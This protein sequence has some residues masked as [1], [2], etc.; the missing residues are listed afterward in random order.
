MVAYRFDLSTGPCCTPASSGG[1]FERSCGEGMEVVRLSA[2]SNRGA[3]SNPSLAS[4]RNM[5]FNVKSAECAS[6]Y[7]R[8]AASTS[9]VQ[10][11]QDAPVGDEQILGYHLPPI[12]ST[13]ARQLSAS[14]VWILAWNSQAA[15]TATRAVP[16]ATSSASRAGTRSKFRQSANKVYTTQPL[17]RKR[18]ELHCLHLGRS[19]RV[20]R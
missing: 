10:S 15:I 18:R 19:V 16:M 12:P 5:T 11:V 6:T 2:R 3:R 20:G 13:A 14:A 1:A 9:G 4:T 8:S 7:A 17:I